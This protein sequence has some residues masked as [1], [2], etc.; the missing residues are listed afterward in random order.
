MKICQAI[1]ILL[2][3]FILFPSFVSARTIKVDTTWTGE[4]MVDEDILVPAGVTLIVA[5]GAS[6]RVTPSESTKIDPEFL[7]HQT[8]ILVRGQLRI[9]GSAPAPVSLA[10]SDPA[11]HWAGIIIDGGRGE[12]HSCII[13]DAETAV[14]VV[15]GVMRVEDCDVNSNRYGLV[16]QGEGANLF[17]RN[18]RVR[19]NE[20]GLFA[21]EGAKVTEE[22]SA[23][24]GNIKNDF[25]RDPSRN[26]TIPVR[27]YTLP[28]KTITRLYQDEVLI[29][30][31]IWQGRIVIDG[32]V[33]LPPEARLIILPGTLIEF[34]KKDTNN[35][36]IGENGLLLQGGFIAKG[37][38]EL[39]IIFKSATSEPCPGDWDAIN[40]MGSDQTQNLIEFC[41]IED[42][43]RGL[44]FH[45]SNVAVNNT[46]IRNSYRAIQFQE[47]VVAIIDSRFHANKS[48]IQARDSEVELRGND[49]FDNWSGA[50][51][52]RSK[53]VA[54]SNRLVDNRL[55]GLR[56]REG[57]SVVEENLLAGNRYGLL[58]ADAVYGKVSRNHLAANSETGILLRNCDQL[59]I[60]NNVMAQNGINGMS[61]QDSRVLIRKNLITENGERGV[62]V[63]S[64][65]GVITENNI[66]DNGRYAIGLDGE[67]DVSAPDNWWGEGDLEAA[68][69]DRH[70][71]ERLGEVLFSPRRETAVSF[72][73]PLKTIEID[74]GW[75]GLIEVPQMLT[76]TKEAGLSVRPGTHIG[77]NKGA[78]MTILGRLIAEG[79]PDRR[80]LF[81]SINTHAPAA[82]DSIILERAG[83]SRLVNCDFKDATWV[84]HSHFTPLVISGCRFTGNE[85]GVRFRAGPLSISRSLFS[86]NKIGIRPYMGLGEFR[87]NVIYG[88]ETGIFVRDGGEGVAIHRNNIY[89]N[90]R[91][92]LR[93]GDFNL[94]NVDARENWWGEGPPADTIFD[95]RKEPGVG[96]V[97]FE[98]FLDKPVDIPVPGDH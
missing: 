66:A 11:L 9:E 81:N 73:W 45:F 24:Q 72:P 60:S 96:M 17:L 53:I 33:R 15:N 97:I 65:S 94:E 68:I 30:T 18:T 98:P 85:G 32:I 79:R 59:E 58:M 77:F 7:S 12:M 13:R 35:D 25:F 86:G 57:T 20:Y 2:W 89:G 88:N 62:G 39:P 47:S 44:H 22:N 70:D 74:T 16:A 69:Y 38:A 93:L 6:I 28:E 83:E 8:E 87:E 82:W 67:T 42:A 46:V 84:V 95:G 19:N 64:F 51:F 26:I 92:N 23:V 4:V 5:A 48:G 52:F 71:E 50:N 56:I 63:L 91:Y 80:I 41:R 10:S 36:R 75:T 78:G 76:V 3:G 21:L 61:I 31:T 14:Q 27:A 34:I 40:I 43:F 1:T 49:L 29:G 37:T 54:R 90:D 55:D